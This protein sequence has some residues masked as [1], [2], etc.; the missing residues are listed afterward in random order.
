MTGCADNTQGNDVFAEQPLPENNTISPDEENEKLHIEEENG[1]N[2]DLTPSEGF[3]ESGVRYVFGG[4]F[5]DVA[6]LSFNDSREKGSL[7]DEETL[8]IAEIPPRIPS[9]AAEVYQDYLLRHLQHQVDWLLEYSEDS[10]IHVLYCPETDNWILGV[11]WPDDW[12]TLG[13]PSYYTVNRTDGSLVWHG[14]DHQHW[15][16]LHG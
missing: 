13:L 11:R 1:D 9:E 12:P 7:V 4:T 10:F 8:W 16:E 14:W 15:E 3:L 2:V 6:G 5:Y